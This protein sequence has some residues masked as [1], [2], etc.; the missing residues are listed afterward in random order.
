MHTSENRED[1]IEMGHPSNTPTQAVLREL[2]E[3]I[4]HLTQQQTQFNAAVMQ[5]LSALEQQLHDQ[6]AIL[7]EQDR[8]QSALVRELAELNLS[9]KRLSRWMDAL[10]ERAQEAEQP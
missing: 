3:L 5:R 7:I 6:G 10:E 9:I 2:A 8:E 1:E 4:K